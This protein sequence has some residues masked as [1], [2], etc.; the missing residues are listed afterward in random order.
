MATDQKT[1]P[2]QFGS[3]EEIGYVGDSMK[4]PIIKD[5]YDP[6][7]DT[8][9]KNLTTYFETL[10]HML[11]V[12]L[13]TGILAMPKAFSNAGYLLG[14][15]GTLAVGALSTY[16]MQMLVRSEYELCKKRRVP[17]MTYAQTFE[18]AFAEGPKT[19]RPLAGAAGVACKI[20]LFLFQGGA[21]CVYIVFVAENLKA[22]GDQ[23]FG[24]TD[25]RLYMAY[26]LGPLILICWLRNFKYL[27]P[28]SSFGNVMTL[29]CYCITFYYM[30]S[31]LPSF[32]TRQAVVEL[33]RFPLFIG[34]AL[35]AMEA[36]GVVMPLKSEMKNPRQ[37]RGWFG[38]LNCAM[39]PITILYLLVGLAGYL[40]YGDSARGS[41]SLNLPDNEVP[42]QC[43]KVMLAF[44]VY[45]CYAICAYVTFQMLWGDY[46]EPK[47]EE[48]KKKL[49][50]E[51]IGRTLLVLVTF[52]LAVSI[53]NLE[54]FI[55]LIGALGLANLGVAFPTIME[56]LTRWDKYH[57]CLFALF[58]LKNI[59]LL[60]V[61][62]Y[63]FFIGGSTSIINIYKKV[64]VGS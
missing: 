60:F 32:S 18:A 39:V 23:Y 3:D 40:K 14:I 47:F 17:R 31:D 58:L 49:V 10:I 16:T 5:D 35:F 44:S 62:V 13:G 43:V 41:I 64:I 38:V 9:D 50:Y 2:P 51:Y 45:I 12:S 28:V 24:K 4:A 33:D 54:L 48:S 37:F 46:L 15:I 52:G 1:N 11:K 7:K 57:G 34:T 56:L 63:A 8:G 36:V 30:L 21:C 55:S 20:I 25:I 27:A 42:A 29:I 19:F 6:D 61:A 26:L 59:C 53:P 22:V